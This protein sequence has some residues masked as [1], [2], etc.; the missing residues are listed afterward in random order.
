MPT[1][2]TPLRQMTLLLPYQLKV[3]ICA[4]KLIK[5]KHPKLFIFDIA[6]SPFFPRKKGTSISNMDLFPYVNSK[7]VY[8]ERHIRSQIVLLY[9]EVT[10]QQCELG[11]KVLESLLLI[12]RLVPSEFALRLMKEPGYISLM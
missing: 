4:Y 7:L 1:N 8:M 2:C 3:T 11:N 9:N 5:T 12:T 6:V 10:L